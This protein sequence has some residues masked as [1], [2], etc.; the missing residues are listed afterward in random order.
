MFTHNP[1]GRRSTFSSTYFCGAKVSPNNPRASFD[2]KKT[3][4][5]TR[6]LSSVGSPVV[7]RHCCGVAG[8]IDTVAR[9]NGKPRMS[10]EFCC[11]AESEWHELLL[12]KANI[13]ALNRIA[14][15]SELFT[16]T[17]SQGETDVKIDFKMGHAVSVLELEPVDQGSYHLT[18]SR[19]VWIANRQGKNNKDA[20]PQPQSTHS[21]KAPN[22]DRGHQG[23]PFAERVT[24]YFTPAL[25]AISDDLFR[26]K[27]KI[28]SATVNW[29]APTCTATTTLGLFDKPLALVMPCLCVDVFA[30]KPS[31]EN[32]K[33]DG[34]SPVQPKSQQNSK[35]P[36]S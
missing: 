27:H 19:C 21:L 11:C 34:N 17:S 35:T 8:C 10:G 9:V 14:I 22:I 24:Y 28:S 12:I 36:I 33:E 3:F 13:A 25:R 1:Y 26:R 7:L 29:N 23:L 31:I 6:E 15:G 4:E 2:L 20:S 18:P 32:T 16:I 5:V 30:V